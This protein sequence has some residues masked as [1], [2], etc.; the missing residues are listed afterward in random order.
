MTP[1]SYVPLSLRELIITRAQGHCEYCQSPA[2]YSPE[3]FEVEHILPVASGGKTTL[4][5]LA[6]ACP[7]CN[8]YKGR[9][10]TSI[11]PLT[12]TEVAL[13]NPRTQRW[14]DHFGWSADLQEITGLTPVG[15]AT[16]ETL[17]M[18][19]PAVTVFRTALSVVGLHPAKEGG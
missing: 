3:V 11:D 2:R 4:D 14:A 1:S 10:Q 13:F 18:N 17:R 16:V 8:R 5:N 6:L 19:R 9:R 15:R 7:A 12:A